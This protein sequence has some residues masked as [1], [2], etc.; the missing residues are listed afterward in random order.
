M[1]NGSTTFRY[2]VQQRKAILAAIPLRAGV[3]SNV[4]FQELTRYANFSLNQRQFEGQLPY[5]GKVLEDFENLDDAIWRA[6]RDKKDKKKAWKEPILSAKKVMSSHSIELVH[7]GLARKHDW[8]YMPTSTKLPELEEAIKEARKYRRSELQD[9]GRPSNRA[10]IIFSALCCNAWRKYATRP[11]PT[12]VK[13]NSPICRFVHAAIPRQLHT[14]RSTSLVRQG[15]AH[16]RRCGPHFT[17][18]SLSSYRRT[19]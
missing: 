16:I 4:V 2:S 1:S 18:A 8:E 12:A 11:L 14:G 9:T 13:V 17:P 19:T 6:T 15:L 10:A 7:M 3:N 5:S